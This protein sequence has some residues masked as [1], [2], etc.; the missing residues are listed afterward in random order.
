MTLGGKWPTHGE[1][2]ALPIIGAGLCR[3]PLPRL[4]IRLPSH[5]STKSTMIFI[6]CSSAAIVDSVWPSL[7]V[8]RQGRDGGSPGTGSHESC[9][10]GYSTSSLASQRYPGSLKGTRRPG[11]MIRIS[12][13]QPRVRGM[14][15]ALSYHVLAV[16]RVQG[17]S[18]T[19]DPSTSQGKLEAETQT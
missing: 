15:S 12:E 8:N 3:L 16:M 13:P 6:E 11:K 9:R 7:K 14:R 19:H 18:T 17:E 10:A 1:V 4:G 2:P 5:R